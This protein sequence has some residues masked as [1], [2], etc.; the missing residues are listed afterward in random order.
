M[1]NTGIG[2]GHNS[3]LGPG[4]LLIALGGFHLGDGDGGRVVVVLGMG[5]SEQSGPVVYLPPLGGGVTA[6]RK[7]HINIKQGTV[8]APA[9]LV[10]LADSEL[11]NAIRVGIALLVP[12]F[13]LGFRVRLDLDVVL[14][15][16]V[17]LRGCDRECINVVGDKVLGPATPGN[18]V[19]PQ[20]IIVVIPIEDLVLRSGSGASAPGND[21]SA[22]DVCPN[23]GLGG[24]VVG[25][26]L[27]G[28]VVVG[29]DL[30]DGRVISLSGLDVV[31]A[32]KLAVPFTAEGHL[33]I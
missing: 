17:F 29:E 9:I 31:A 2:G 27:A 10:V 4:V 13:G 32:G 7:G 16:R 5:P 20:V 12:N 6:I 33:A 14:I 15:L 1:G 28:I 21:G 22:H 3:R 24:G 11:A 18:I 23:G 8:Q 30:L 19:I 26:A 25:I